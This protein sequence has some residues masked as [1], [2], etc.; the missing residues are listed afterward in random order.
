[1]PKPINDT[2]WK[3][4]QIVGGDGDESAAGR[5]EMVK[6]N[7]TRPCCLCRSWEKNKRR[8]VEHLM[9]HGLTPRPDGTFETP[10]A[11][12][13]PG[14]KSMILNPDNMGFCR[15]DVLPTDDLATCENWEAVRTA[16]EL[17]SRIK[18]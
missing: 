3:R 16:S 1:M 14:R 15:R 2:G 5:V 8:L 17:E 4:L 13:I 12:D 18:P 6:G 7:E 10:I 9:A 11:K